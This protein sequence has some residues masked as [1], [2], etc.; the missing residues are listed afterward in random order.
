MILWCERDKGLVIVLSLDVTRLYLS[1]Q[2][3][4]SAAIDRCELL[5][6]CY[7]PGRRP[8]TSNTGEEKKT[9]DGLRDRSAQS[10]LK[11]SNISSAK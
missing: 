7:P 1:A 2:R 4:A 6:G 11:S 5:L 8:I 3:P 9:V 10:A